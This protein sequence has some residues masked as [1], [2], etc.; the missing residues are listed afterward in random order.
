L[1]RGTSVAER[2]NSATAAASASEDVLMSDS[3]GGS[4]QTSVRQPQHLQAGQTSASYRLPNPDTSSRR[5]PAPA[6][7]RLVQPGA[8]WTNGAIPVH[9]NCD[10][11][12]C[13]DASCNPATATKKSRVSFIPLREEMDEDETKTTGI[14]LVDID[15]LDKF[16]GEVIEKHARECREGHLKVKSQIKNGYELDRNYAC[17]TCGMEVTY[18]TGPPPDPNA[19][20]TKG[21]FKPRPI[22]TIMS[23]GI[24]NCGAPMQHIR[25]LFAESGVI[26]PSEKGQAKMME[27]VQA[28]VKKVSQEELVSNRKQH[29]A[30]CRALN[31]YAGDHKFK[32]SEGVE[33]SIARG[34]ITTDGNGEKR[35]YGHIITGQQHALVC[36]SAVTGMPIA[37]WHDQISCIR[38]SL[39]LTQ[40]MKDGEVERVQDLSAADLSHEGTCYRNRKI[41]PDDEAILG[42]FVI[43]DGDTRGPLRFISRQA[44][45]VGDSWKGKA[46]YC[47]DIGHFIKCISNALFTLANK[48]TELR[49]KNL[50]EP[51]RIKVLVSDILKYIREYG[52]DY[53]AYVSTDKS[54]LDEARARCLRRI[55]N[56]IHHHCGDHGGCEMGDCKYLQIEDEIVAQY[57]EEFGDSKSREEIIALKLMDIREK[58]ADNSRFSGMSMSMGQNARKKVLGVIFSRITPD[59]IDRVCLCLSSNPCENFFSVLVKY[60]SGKRVYLGKKDGWEVRLNFVAASKSNNRLTDEVRAD[61]NIKE[62]SFVREKSTNLKLKRKAYQAA[63]KK[64]E[65]CKKRRTLQKMGSKVALQANSKDPARHRSDKLKAK[66]IG[67]ST[68]SKGSAEPRRKKT[69]KTKCSN[70]KDI[71]PGMNCPEPSYRPVKSRKKPSKLCDPAYLSS[72]F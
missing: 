71:H 26:S 10:D 36:I 64:S 43:A 4:G 21:R 2:G 6:Q 24:F 41:R 20:K 62:T 40:L 23:V 12:D 33:H 15:S 27:K 38:C 19:P 52:A 55:E 56:L 28:S 70:C 61:L 16:I 35:A 42:D 17:S 29:V 1:P 46:Q 60:T 11:V 31:D 68:T 45:L 18:R 69:K 47:P 14:A 51:V 57:T 54:K 3:D 30:A 72:L 9:T 34:P 22:N 50:L 44:E 58:Y 59:C 7:N 25:E 66:D 65:G 5:A 53:K 67:K 39:K 48:N 13:T 8:G 63:Y 37:I 49:G 32:D